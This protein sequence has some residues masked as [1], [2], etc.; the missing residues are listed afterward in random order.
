MPHMTAT[1]AGV[2]PGHQP[3]PEGEFTGGPIA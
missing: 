1:A 3:A 2:A